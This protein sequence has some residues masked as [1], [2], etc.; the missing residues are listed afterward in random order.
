M[1]SS[2]MIENPKKGFHTVV[3]CKFSLQPQIA[4]AKK[5]ATV[6]KCANVKFSNKFEGKP[7][8]FERTTKKKVEEKSKSKGAVQKSFKKGM[9]T[10][11]KKLKYLQAKH[12]IPPEYLL[13]LKNNYQSILIHG[14]STSAII[15]INPYNWVLLYQYWLPIKQNYM[16]LVCSVHVV[17]ITTGF[18]YSKRR[19]LKRKHFLDLLCSIP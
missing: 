8:Y 6:G 1:N 17:I 14:Y 4:K 11:K 7:T 19:G 16:D 2:P 5:T 15:C 18:R 13:I 3:K 9:L 10:I 12:G